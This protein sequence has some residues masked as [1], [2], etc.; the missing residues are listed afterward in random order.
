MDD[1]SPYV[2]GRAVEALGL[3]ARSDS[4]VA[5][6]DV[7]SAADDD[8]A[9]F[10][11]DRVRYATDEDD[12]PGD[13]ALEKI[14]TIPALRDRTDEIVDEITAPDGDECPYCGLSL[15]EP[16]PPICPQCGGPR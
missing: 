8:A 13:T 12:G 11:A 4:D 15:P 6:P 3:L 2:R 10:L 5:I 9:A 16:G 14:G 1:E 7:R